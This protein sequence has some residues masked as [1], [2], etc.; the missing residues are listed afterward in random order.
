MLPR[1][2][3]ACWRSG[4]RRPRC[5]C[6]RHC[7]AMSAGANALPYA[8]RRRCGPRGRGRRARPRSA[9]P[10][11]ASQLGC[12]CQP[13]PGRLASLAGRLGGGDARSGG[14]VWERRRR[15][16]EQQCASKVYQMKDAS[17]PAACCAARAL[18]RRGRTASA[19]AS[20][21]RPL[22]AAEVAVGGRGRRAGHSLG[23]PVPALCV[24]LAPWLFLCCMVWLKGVSIAAK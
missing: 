2:E 8:R 9:S 21:E 16:W 18:R 15:P 11:G 12:L 24:Q 7:H 10:P 17:T 4:A 19:Q 20:C 22:R 1:P 5:S 3:S 23:C 6:H 14:A 13:L